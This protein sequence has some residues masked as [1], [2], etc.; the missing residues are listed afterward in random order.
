M[1]T[2][3]EELRAATDRRSVLRTPDPVAAAGHGC[4]DGFH[5]ANILALQRTVGNAAVAGLQRKAAS[6]SGEQAESEQEEVET[7]SLGNQ[8]EDLDDSV[9]KG[10]DDRKLD[11]PSLAPSSLPG[12]RPATA[13]DGLRVRVGSL[14]LASSAPRQEAIGAASP[15]HADDPY[16]G[17]VTTTW[18]NPGGATVGAFGAEKFKPTWGGCQAKRQGGDLT[19]DFTIDVQ[20]PWGTNDGGRIDVD[21]A[22]SSDVTTDVLP[23]GR[24]KYQQI[25]DDLTPV[26]KR[27]S[28][29]A[30]RA[31]FW[32]KAICERHET[33]HSTDDRDWAASQ[34]KAAVKNFI[35][36]QI[37]DP[38]DGV[39][40]IRVLLDASMDEMKSANMDFYTGGA[41]KY[42]DY[43]GEE[44]AFGD[45]KAPYEALSGAVKARGDKMVADAQAA[46]AL[47]AGTPPS[48]AP[49]S[50]ASAPT[51]GGSGAGVKGLANRFQQLIDEQAPK[52]PPR[53]PR[54][55]P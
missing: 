21:S 51:S 6:D 19:L 33:F 8:T 37:I 17:N 49:P 46:A 55:R 14:G 26:Q 16:A 15:S 5:V 44:R 35:E 52:G 10:P 28:W 22:S 13:S 38:A 18:G 11:G 7:F 34:G 50:G 25:V 9:V 45:G 41:A 12:R 32:S 54:G 30:P 43:A 48:T 42:Y 40:G 39:A 29:V 4:R 20:C 23:N 47:T 36:T 27:K 1:H 31:M 3:D 2:Q 53:T 24:M